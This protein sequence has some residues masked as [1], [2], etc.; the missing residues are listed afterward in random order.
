M[1]IYAIQ[2][3]LGFLVMLFLS[4]VAASIGASVGFWDQQFIPHVTLGVLAAW[5]LF[6]YVKG[7]KVKKETTVP[8]PGMEVTEEVGHQQNGEAEKSVLKTLGKILFKTFLIIFILFAILI[9]YATYQDSSAE[10]Q[11]KAFCD[12]SIAGSNISEAIRRAKKMKIRH[13]SSD[14]PPVH[15]FLFQGFVFSRYNCTIT[16]GAGKVVSKRIGH[17]D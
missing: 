9:G 11:A 6:G 4:W 8:D 10:K 16:T 13:W 1:F 7:R 15:Y 5:L 2:L 14:Q 17:I 3:I 12:S